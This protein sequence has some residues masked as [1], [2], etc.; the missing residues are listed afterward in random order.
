MVLLKLY[1]TSV[2]RF[3]F[4]MKNFT[5]KILILEPKN[6]PERRRIG[7]WISGIAPT[8][9]DIFAFSVHFKLTPFPDPVHL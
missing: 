9:T 8:P 4:S 5:D 6:F 3:I 7:F 1:S 2:C